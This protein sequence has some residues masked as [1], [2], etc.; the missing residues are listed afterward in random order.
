MSEVEPNAI[1]G[2]HPARVGAGLA[3]ASLPAHFA[4]SSTA[5]HQLAA[6]VLVLVA[7]IYVGFAVQDGRAKTIAIEGSI[8]IVFAAAALAGLWVSAWAIPAAYALHGFWD[9]AHHRHV[10]TAMPAWYV[11]FC[12]VFDWVFAAGLAAAWLLR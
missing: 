10:A 3:L 7:G 9:L 6:I 4:L 11:P 8:A 5:S 12:A 2:R 1:V